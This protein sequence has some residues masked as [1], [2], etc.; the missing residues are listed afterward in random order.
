MDRVACIDIGTNSV[1]LL[2]AARSDAGVVALTERAT[3][4]RL[5]EGVDRTRRLLDAACE[6]TLRCLE[7][8]AGTIA[9][10]GVGEVIA[11]GT[12]AMRDAAGG[13]EFRARA[14]QI[15][16]VAPRVISGGEE[17]E[18]TFAGALSGLDTSGSVVVFDVG[19]GS[20]EVIGGTKGGHIEHAVSLD[21]GSVRLFER[22]LHDD[23]PTPSQCASLRDYVREALT[24]LPAPAGSTPLVGVAGTVTTLAAIETRLDE[25]VG[26][27]VHGL[28]LSRS[29]VE[30]IVQR[31]AELPVATRRTLVGLAPKRADVI[32]AGGLL[33]SEVM[34]WANA[35]ALL[36]SDRGVRWG[37]AEQ[38]LAG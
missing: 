17:A 4:T 23:P 25:Y 11:V 21:I 36:V 7:D 22:F 35:D 18:L 10:H 32:V 27:K 26:S 6:R 15:L 37:L 3:I 20:T 28:S 16:G 1:L 5:G 2:V 12:S 30:A 34:A 31:L 19:G 24:T 13:D 8:Y 33:V 38:A 14:A 9:E 29:N